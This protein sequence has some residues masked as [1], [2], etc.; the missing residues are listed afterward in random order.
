MV[1]TAVKLDASKLWPHSGRTSIPTKIYKAPHHNDITSNQTRT[2]QNSPS[3]PYKSAIEAWKRVAE[4]RQ[5]HS[6]RNG[7]F[8]SPTKRATATP[9]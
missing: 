6:R 1:A 8:D 3:Q 4:T 2:T 5:A 7:R 9:P